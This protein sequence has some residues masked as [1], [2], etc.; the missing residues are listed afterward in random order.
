MINVLLEKL[1]EALP[2][3]LSILIVLGFS[4]LALLLA[5]LMT[6]M[7]IWAVRRIQWKS[8]TVKRFIRI[9]NEGNLA[10]QLLLRVDGPQKEL[11]FQCLLDGN[12][13]PAATAVPQVYT[14]HR[15]PSAQPA[16][17][18]VE[19]QRTQA[20]PAVSPQSGEA[21]DA[22]KKMAESAAKAKEKSKKGLGFARLV[23]GIFG[24]LGG[25]LPGSLG[26]SFKEKSADLQKA[27]QDASTKMQMPEQKLKSVEHLKGQVNQLNPGADGE[28]SDPKPAVSSQKP[29]NPP[30]VPETGAEQKLPAG[31]DT[32]QARDM[33]SSGFLQTPPLSPGESLSL[34]LWIDPIHPYRSGEYSFAVLV[35]QVAL[36]DMPPMEQLSDLTSRGRVE[37]V[38]LSPIY[39][40]LSLLMVLCAVVLNGTWVVLFISWLAGFVL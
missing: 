25:L 13:L 12:A 31:K 24:S 10:G 20:A 18:S 28:K 6:F 8:Q 19:A 4:L 22:K 32:F 3:W 40:I 38:G 26:A 17:A 21:G 16:R 14:S 36:P 30:A 35:R 2:N 11:K 15:Y 34:E 9:T 33:R 29:S 7:L 5:V 1:F 27:T 23:S 39:W 37:I